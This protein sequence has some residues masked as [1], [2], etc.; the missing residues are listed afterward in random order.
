ML[1]F[2]ELTLIK[3]LAA[4]KFIELIVQSIHKKKNGKMKFTSFIFPFFII[5]YLLM[6]AVVSRCRI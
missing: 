1:D 3:E 5:R 4:A 2:V 6:P